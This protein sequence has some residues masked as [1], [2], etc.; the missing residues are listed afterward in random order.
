MIP[1]FHRRPFE[2]KFIAGA[3]NVTTKKLAIDV[4]LGLKLI[5]KKRKKKR[6]TKATVKL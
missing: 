1:K 2:Y 6:S 5:K 4:N 3:S